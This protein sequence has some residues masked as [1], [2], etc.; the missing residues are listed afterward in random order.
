[1]DPKL[2]IRA[3][4]ILASVTIFQVLEV[5]RIPFAGKVT[6][7]IRCP[8]HKD[9]TPSARV[10]A[11]NNKVYCFTCAK[12]WD[13]IEL[14]RSKEGVDFEGSLVWLETQFLVPPASANLAQV[15]RGQI[16]RKVEIKPDELYD[17]VER[18][19]LARRDA[20]GLLK[21]TKAFYA[22][23]LL[24]AQA[25]SRV[26]SSDRFESGARAILKYVNT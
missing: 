17:Y 23:D 13:V 22:L 4:A 6:Q 7:Q 5:Y 15:I 11:D 9:R 18:R 8:V 14:V 10:Y 12:L 25:K 24:L 26:I 21:Y 16:R 3:S 19:I 20:L 2:S 1:M